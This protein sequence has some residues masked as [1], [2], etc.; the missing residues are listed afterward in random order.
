MATKGTST[1]VEQAS[2]NGSSFN[3]LH[4]SSRL[5]PPYFSDFPNPPSRH[6]TSP[7]P[8]FPL[9]LTPPIPL[10]RLHQHHPLSLLH[11]NLSLA[12]RLIRIQR[13]HMSKFLSA[14]LGRNSGPF[15][16]DRGGGGGEAGGDGGAV[17]EVRALDGRR[18]FGRRDGVVEGGFGAVVTVAEGLD[19]GGW[20]ETGLVGRVRGY[21]E[22]AA[23]VCGGCLLARLAWSSVVKGIEVV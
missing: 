13:E 1:R 9:N 22:P 12:T 20:H 8:P 18:V 7:S 14:P 21:A 10:I 15:L 3:T 11:T 23:A 19:V 5:S 4:P 6:N 17:G 16:L 2:L